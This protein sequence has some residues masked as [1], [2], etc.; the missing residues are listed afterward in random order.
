MET[1]FCLICVTFVDTLGLF[2][3]RCV[4]MAASSYTY[5]KESYLKAFR[6]DKED[7]SRGFPLFYISILSI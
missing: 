4:Y 1:I 2:V 6:E 3:C 5:P 7:Q